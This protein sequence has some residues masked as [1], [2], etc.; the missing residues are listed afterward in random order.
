[1]ETAHA[2]LA[3]QPEAVKQ[4]FAAYPP[5]FFYELKGEG[6]RC[7]IIRYLANEDDS[8][9]HCEVAMLGP[10]HEGDDS[11]VVRLTDLTRKESTEGVS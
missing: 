4:A 6:E 1:M 7:Q 2:W 3:A 10:N 11:Q 9:T 8:V 5:Y